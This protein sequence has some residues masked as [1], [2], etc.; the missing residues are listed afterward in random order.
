VGMDCRSNIQACKR[1]SLNIREMPLKFCPSCLSEVNNFANHMISVK[2]N[3]PGGKM[4]G[5]TNF[6]IK[7]IN[8]SPCDDYYCWFL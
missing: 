1:I 6:F 2:M 5:V 7:N 8:L 4:K 3:K